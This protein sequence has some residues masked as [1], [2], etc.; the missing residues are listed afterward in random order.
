MSVTIHAENI[1]NIYF[2]PDD[3]PDSGVLPGPAPQL[4]IEAIYELP[5]GEAEMLQDNKFAAARAVFPVDPNETESFP[6]YAELRAA[7]A[8]DAPV[9]F[10]L[11]PAGSHNRLVSVGPEEPL[12]TLSLDGANAT[13]PNLLSGTPRSLDELDDTLGGANTQVRSLIVRLEDTSGLGYPLFVDQVGHEASVQDVKTNYDAVH[14]ALLEH[15]EE[16][17]KLLLVLDD[18][19]IGPPGTTDEDQCQDW[20]EQDTFLSRLLMTIYGCPVD[21]E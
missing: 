20:A 19:S 18:D 4:V 9:V 17:Y 16:T 5:D 21:I 12:S 6:G 1:E 11:S 14:L 3:V 2:T 8:N 13:L 7:V 15:E 10:W